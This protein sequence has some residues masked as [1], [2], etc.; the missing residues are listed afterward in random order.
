MEG[1][2]RGDRTSVFFMPFSVT[3][4]FYET[5]NLMEKSY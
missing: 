1:K 5:S 4:L 2:N 3:L